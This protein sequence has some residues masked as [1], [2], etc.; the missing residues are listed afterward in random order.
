MSD[1]V[2]KI[3]VN[4]E[5]LDKA[6][7]KLKEV[8][9][10]E[11]ETNKILQKAKGGNSPIKGLDKSTADTIKKFK[12]LDKIINSDTASISKMVSGIG[13]LNKGLNVTGLLSKGV[14]AG[15]GAMGVAIGGIGAVAGGVAAAS[16][17][18]FSFGKTILEMQ[19]QQHSLGLSLGTIKGLQR[20]SLVHGYDEGTAISTIQTVQN[21]KNNVTTQGTI[22]AFLGIDDKKEIENTDSLTLSNK[23]LEKFGAMYKEHGSE[24]RPIIDSWASTLGLSSEAL[25]PLIRRNAQFA[26]SGDFKSWDNPAEAKTLKE[27]EIVRLEA[28]DSF[29]DL[30]KTLSVE[31]APALT[32]L[33]KEVKKLLESDLVKNVFKKTGEVI[34]DTL[35]FTTSAMQTPEHVMSV[36]NNYKNWGEVLDS[37]NKSWT[38]GEKSRARVLLTDM[39]NYFKNDGEIDQTEFNN[40]RMTRGWR[41]TAN[42][43]FEEKPELKEKFNQD[44]AKWAEAYQVPFQ[45]IAAAD[46]QLDGTAYA[47]NTSSQNITI[48]VNA[49]SDNASDIVHALEDAVHNLEIQMNSTHFITT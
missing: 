46:Y 22:G 8:K 29:E 20:G 9:D 38:V 43:Y 30:I 26:T 6:I 21:N 37:K 23:I 34:S 27:A 41:E 5:E 48:N 45:P 1:N 12:E 10:G 4:T 19:A 47:H 49:N 2:F 24:A 13:D 15:F 44:M 36:A 33:T 11:R 39:D 16:N 28:K 17:K 31:V 40:I 7:A 25:M 32:N 42:W 14:I 35:E 3:E 18:T